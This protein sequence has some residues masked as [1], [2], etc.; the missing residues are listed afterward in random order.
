LRLTFLNVC[1]LQQQYN[2]KHSRHKK[3]D[4]IT[5]FTKSLVLLAR[6]LTKKEYDLVANTMFALHN[7]VTFGYHNEFDPAMIND[8]AQIYKIHKPKTY[9]NNIVKLKMVSS[10][11]DADVKL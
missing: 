4:G 1:L 7:G 8:A 6:H 2:N 9:K 10:R 5:D 11:K 3:K